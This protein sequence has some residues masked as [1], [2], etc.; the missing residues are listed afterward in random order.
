MSRRKGIFRAIGVVFLACST[1]TASAGG[2]S[3]ALAQNK[4]KKSAPGKAPEKEPGRGLDLDRIKGELES[5]DEK[6]MSRA[7][8]ELEKAGE[9]AKDAAPLVQALLDRG[10]SLKVL[11]LALNAAGAMKQMTSSASVAPYVKHRAPE[12]RRAAAKALIKTRGP[13]AVKA[14]RQALRS[15]DAV[16]RGTA[17]TGLGSL[18]AREALA[19]LFNALDHNVAEAAASIGQLCAPEECEKFAVRLGKQPFDVMTSGFDQILFRPATDMPDDQKI[20]IVG[21]LRELG[22]KDAGTY[23]ADVAERWPKDWS[24]RVKQAIDSAVKATGGSRGG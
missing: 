22:T 18:L 6:R 17:A 9:G 10:A 8:E 14:L 19:D 21:R 16:V 12:V 23:L 15:G 2:I 20:R 24:R 5:G 11:A 4:P 13:D 1:L 7:L 3:A